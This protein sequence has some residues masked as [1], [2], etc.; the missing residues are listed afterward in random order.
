MLDNLGVPSSRKILTELYSHAVSG[1][2]AS[3][4]KNKALH[5]YEIVSVL[6]L[7]ADR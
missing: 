1:S 7:S 4:Q 6:C 3:H 2:I 5:F